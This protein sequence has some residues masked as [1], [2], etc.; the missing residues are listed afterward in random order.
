MKKLRKLDKLLFRL[1]QVAFILALLMGCSIMGG[2][3][4]NLIFA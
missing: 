4:I 3:I 1:L 2:V